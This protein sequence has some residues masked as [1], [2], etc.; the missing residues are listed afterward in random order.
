MARMARA[1]VPGVAHY[2]TQRGGRRRKVFFEDG[3]YALYKELLAQGCAAAGVQV[4]A[5][6]LM[7]DVVHL[8]LVPGDR[9]GLR[10]ALGETHRRY[11]RTV[12]ARE[13]RRGYLWQGR[14]AS[15]AMDE[16]Q[17]S[18][19]ARYVEQSPVR[20][21]FVERARDWRWSSTRAH[22]KG[23]DDGMVQVKPL[24]GRLGDWRRFL[25]VKLSGGEAD[26]IGVSARTGRPRG[27]PSFVSRIERKL[28]RILA[29]QKPGPKARA[30][31]ARRRP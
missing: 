21:R 23:R 13:G 31:A 22:L 6:C 8:I 7:P 16:G 9:D 2:V 4:W 15:F 25:G 29:K 26:A 11:S 20:A 12:N 5:Y 28:E 27:S 24:L 19:C 3:D 1:V 17:L 18:A 10:A 14:F 30:Q